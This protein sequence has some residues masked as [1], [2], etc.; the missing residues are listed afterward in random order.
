MIIHWP[1]A[2]K[3]KG[4]LRS[5]WHH[6][7]DIT[8]TILE[9]AG[10]PEPKV[11]NGI[12]QTPIEGKSMLYTFDDATARD[13]H[14]IQYFEIFGNR[15]IYH[16]GWLAGTVHRAPWEYKPRATL[17]NDTWELYDTR[18]DF[19]LANDLAAKNPERL[20]AMQALFM[21]EAVKN[22]VLP[23]DDRTLE[24]LNP[25]LAGRPDL[26]AGRTSLTV[27][28]GMTG[29][30]ENVFINTKNCSH[31]I[32][33]EADIPKDGANGVILA[34][35]GRFGGWSLYLKDGKPTYT[36]N[37]L[38]LNRYTI[39]A[40][41]TVPAGKAT[42]RYEFSYDGGGPRKGGMGTIFVNGAKVA[43][44][45]IE[46]TQGFAF[47]ADEGADVGEDGET[48]VVEDYGIPAPYVF[49][50]RLDRVT[51]DLKEMKTADKEAADRAQ[52]DAALKKEMS[53]RVKISH[54]EN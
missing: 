35:A 54:H 26:M 18:S 42:I 33:A 34:Q 52:K 15:A 38:G 13:R 50:G 10:L 45:R 17:E 40:S 43:G 51:I 29:I 16:D 53:D 5:Q 12:P 32:T 21:T 3:A 27:Y 24:R 49:T 14:L 19:S 9:A 7:I 39:A 6:V 47:S 30:S 44:G 31:T 1:R 2:F 48:P 46:K 41:A 28:R 36:Y 37:W 4:E 8:P 25:A 22:S 23:L 20:K 11:V